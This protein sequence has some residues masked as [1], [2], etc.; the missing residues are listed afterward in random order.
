[1]GLSHGDSWKHFRSNAFASAFAIGG[2]IC[3]NSAAFFACPILNNAVTGS[4]DQNGGLVV[5]ISTT[6]APVL[7]RKY[8]FAARGC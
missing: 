3:S 8:D 7:L 5:S 6:S 4:H 1:M 2:I